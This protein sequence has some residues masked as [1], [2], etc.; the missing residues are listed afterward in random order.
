[1]NITKAI[2]AVMADVGAIGKDS[3]NQTQGFMYRGVDAVMNALQPAMVK[4]GIFVM[5]EVLEQT[6]EERQN[7]KGTT[8]LYSILRVKYTFFADDGS[9]VSA[10]VIGEGMDT[11]DKASNKAM[12]VAF[13]Y[14]CFQVFC[15]PTEE[16]KDPDAECHEVKPK[17]KPTMPKAHDVS[18]HKIGQAKV[19]ALTAQCE[20]DGINPAFVCDVC[21]VK[22][23]SELTEKQF[24]WLHENWTK[25]VVNGVQGNS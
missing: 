18:Q 9:N 24:V 1:M 5:P 7:A 19:N 14:A 8:L 11:G 25:E 17:A 10:V 13:K 23:L 15:I 16:M 12:S 4:H 3:K 20:K 6:R 2:N 21:N 22:D